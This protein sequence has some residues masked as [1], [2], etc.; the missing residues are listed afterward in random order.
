MNGSYSDLD[1]GCDGVE[2]F[3][4]TLQEA[5]HL[6]FFSSHSLRFFRSSAPSPPEW[7]SRCLARQLPNSCAH[8]CL[9][10]SG[11][12]ARA[13][14]M[15]KP[16]PAE[17]NVAQMNRRTGLSF[18]MEISD[19]SQYSFF[20][21]ETSRPDAFVPPR[22]QGNQDAAPALIWIPRRDRGER[23]AIVPSIRILLGRVSDDRHAMAGVRVKLLPGRASLIRRRPRHLGHATARFEHRTRRTPALAIR[24]SF[25]PSRAGWFLLGRFRCARDAH[26]GTKR[27]QPK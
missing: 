15:P 22:E 11:P 2:S 24:L 13:S 20:R 8:F 17:I 16:S 25:G 3:P 12:P 5:S 7:E 18:P 10:G 19:F 21:R 9:Q 23:A 6:L 14:C 4:E 27:K 26:G 1:D